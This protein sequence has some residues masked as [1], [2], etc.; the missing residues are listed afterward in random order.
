MRKK[1]IIFLISFFAMKKD[2]RCDKEYL[3]S[4]EHR[5]ISFNNTLVAFVL[6]NSVEYVSAFM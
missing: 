1:I 4:K 6:F 3:Q 2:L 5:R